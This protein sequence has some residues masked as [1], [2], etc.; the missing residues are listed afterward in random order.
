MAKVVFSEAERCRIQEL[1]SAL[2]PTVEEFFGDA[3]DDLS[4][5]EWDL[6]MEYARARIRRTLLVATALHAVCDRHERPA[7]TFDGRG[8]DAFVRAGLRAWA[9]CYPAI[10]DPWRTVFLYRRL[11]GGERRFLADLE[12]IETMALNRLFDSIDSQYERLLASET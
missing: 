2:V 4:L 8:R 9:D 10:E 11:A 12:T 6:L 3:R 1:E 7:T 5:E